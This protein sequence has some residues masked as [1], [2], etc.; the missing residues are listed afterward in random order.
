MPDRL[1]FTPDGVRPWVRRLGAYLRIFGGRGDAG[2]KEHRW[3]IDSLTRMAQKKEDE[4][5][6]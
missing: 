1:R 6:R 4:H 3:Y 2:T 5:G